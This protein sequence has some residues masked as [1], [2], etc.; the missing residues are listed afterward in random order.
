MAEG[1]ILKVERPERYRSDDLEQQLARLEAEG[2][3]DEM[4]SLMNGK[5]PRVQTFTG[6]TIDKE[7]F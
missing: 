5:P 1:L 2:R 3:L 4:H 7:D 6:A